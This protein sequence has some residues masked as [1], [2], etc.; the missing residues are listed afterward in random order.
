MYACLHAAG[1]AALLVECAGY[2]SPLFEV[3]SPDAVLIDLQGLERLFG[4][5]EEIAAAI[6]NRAGLPVDVAIAEDLDTALLAA[7][8]FRGITIVPDGQEADTLAP[9]PINLLPSSPE[10]AAVLDSWGIR[11]LGQFAALPEAGVAARLG[12]EGSHLHQMVRGKG[13]R[14]LRPI[15]E[16]IRYDEELELESPI[17]L[18][19]SLSFLLARVLND[20]CERLRAASL[21]TDEIHLSLTLENAPVHDCALRLPLPMTNP[22]LFLKLLQLEL[23]AHPPEAPILKVRLELKPAKPRKEQHSLFLALSPEPEKLEITLSKL[24]HLLGAE[25]VGTPELLDTHRPDG[26]RMK[27][28]TGRSVTNLEPLPE[29]PALVLRRY[30]PPR[31]AQVIQKDERPAQVWA[32]AIRGS[33]VTC[34]GPWRTSG[35]WWMADS[36]SRDEWDAALSDGSLYRLYCDLHTKHWFVE[37]VYD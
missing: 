22:R 8:G 6:T 29:R 21:S 26:F 24:T 18:L 35:D 2:F 19:E 11:T 33:V 31:H 9:L 14:Q 27:R 13:K 30:R 4:S 1:N 20:L 10:V 15:R 23:N 17:E 3:T 7:H 28:F 5:A 32:G 34:A 25:N 37:G 12:S 36:W 16:P